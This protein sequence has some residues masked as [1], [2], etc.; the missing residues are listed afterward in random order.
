[1][2]FVEAALLAIAAALSHFY[3]GLSTG[4][5][6]AP[7]TLVVIALTSFAMGVRN[8]TI[9]RLSLSDLKTTVLTLTLTGLAADYPLGGD[10]N[11]NVPRRI[12]SV[13]LIAAGA[14]VGAFLFLTFGIFLPLIVIAA[15]VLISTMLY[16]ITTEEKRPREYLDD[17]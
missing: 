6:M 8:S 14:A 10:K 4:E 5:T 11:Q 13:L 3:V 17:V 15:M 12:V 1:M 2:A 9:E 16:S 7:A